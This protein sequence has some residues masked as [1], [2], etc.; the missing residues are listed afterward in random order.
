MK[1][2]DQFLVSH[3]NVIFIK[4]FLRLVSVEPVANQRFHRLGKNHVG[5]IF[6]L[7]EGQRTR[8]QLVMNLK[9]YL[10]EYNEQL[11]G[12]NLWLRLPQMPESGNV[13]GNEKVKYEVFATNE[14]AFLKLYQF[15]FDSDFKR[16]SWQYTNSFVNSN[17]LTLSYSPSPLQ[18]FYNLQS[19]VTQLFDNGEINCLWNNWRF[20]IIQLRLIRL[21]PHQVITNFAPNANC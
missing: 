3:I 7:T 5:T 16:K 18:F 8:W 10:W 4:H 2:M 9:E 1:G 12:A 14:S 21:K 20:N 13:T 17:S 15:Y 6:N 11:S 19:T